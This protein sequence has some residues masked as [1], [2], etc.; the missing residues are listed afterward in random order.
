MPDEP[1][2]EPDRWQEALAFARACEVDDV[3]RAREI[4]WTSLGTGFG[5]ELR[6]AGLAVVAVD[7]LVALTGRSR[8]E[9]WASLL[10]QHLFE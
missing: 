1:S 10:P 5:L 8:D 7:Q 4:S 6:I 3:E 9:V 2:I